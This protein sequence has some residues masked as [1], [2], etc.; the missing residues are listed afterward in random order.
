MNEDLTPFLND[1][2]VSNVRAQIAKKKGYNPYRATIK[3]AGEVITDYDVFPYTR[4]WRGVTLS[5]APIVA[6]REAGWRPRN[7]DCYR[8]QDPPVQ[9][10]A[11]YPNHCMQSA[12]STVYPCYPEY[13][14]R[15]ADSNLLETLLNKS[16]IIQYR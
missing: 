16:C 14:A 11:P 7:D 4:W 8:I 2:N 3:E 9:N 12:C 13:L 10:P 6:E 5:S 1:Y 15:Y